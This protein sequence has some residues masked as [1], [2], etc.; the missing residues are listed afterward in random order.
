MG[1]VLAGKYMRAP[2]V[3]NCKRHGIN[4][5][6]VPETHL[7]MLALLQCPTEDA[8]QKDSAEKWPLYAIKEVTV[9]EENLERRV[10][11]HMQRS[12]CKLRSKAC[13][14]YSNE[15]HTSVLRTSSTIV[16]ERQPSQSIC[17]SGVQ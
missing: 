4:G 17:I 16:D 12:K 6:C 15:L 8:W 11:I 3:D 13:V 2:S 1:P 5:K 9:L 10:L 7:V 14:E